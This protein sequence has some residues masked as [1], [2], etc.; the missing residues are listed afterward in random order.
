MTYLITHYKGPQGWAQARIAP[1]TSK[2]LT[3]FEREWIEWMLD[4][5]SNV[6]TIGETMLELQTLKL[7]D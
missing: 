5:G 6:V 3:P 2:T 7:N 4:H 1:T